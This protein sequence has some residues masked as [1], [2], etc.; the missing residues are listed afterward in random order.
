MPSSLEPHTSLDAAAVSGPVVSNHSGAP[1]T[2]SMDFVG[3]IPKGTFARAAVSF[4]V[5][6]SIAEAAQTAYD[7]G[8]LTL[9]GYSGKMGS[10]KDT[11]ADTVV[12]RLGVPSVHVSFAQTMKNEVDLVIASILAARD[13][14]HATQIVATEFGVSYD[15]AEHSVE[16]V[17]D[18]VNSDPGLHARSRHPAIRSLLQFWGTEL[19]RAQ[20]PD[21]WVK[22][23]LIPAVEE[24]A[25][26][27]SIRI[28]DVRFPNEASPSQALGV[29]IVRL[30]VSVETQ[31]AR[32]IS[33]DGHLPEADAFIHDTETALDSY[34]DFDLVVDN[35]G[36]IDP[37]VD[38]MIRL[39]RYGS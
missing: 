32:L 15:D 26:G 38:R 18:A 4:G 16:I 2:A 36:A 31:A 10:G 37:V 30:D 8:K 14:S 11:I 24:I 27:N 35:N 12:N 20:D 7:S 34:P 17:W 22:R 9:M 21:Y 6:E 23:T 1:I 5:A 29:W 25:Q 3:R 28:T 19:R 39:A 33:R 13:A